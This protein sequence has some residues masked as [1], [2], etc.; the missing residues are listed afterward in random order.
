MNK[1]IE[2]LWYK[3]TRWLCLL[4]L[5]FPFMLLY[6]TVVSVRRYILTR[7]FQTKFSVPIIVVGNLT[8]GGVG[9]TPLVIEIARRFQEQGFRVGIVS[10]GYGATV[11]IFPCVVS[12]TSDP[13]LYGDEPVLIAKRTGCPVVISPKRV[14][15]IQ[16][17][18]ARESCDVIISDDG[19]QHYAMGRAIEIAV[20]DGVRQ[21]GNQHCLPAG[22]LREPIS[23]LSTVDF[24]IVNGSNPLSTS[25]VPR[26][27]EYPMRFEI[28]PLRM[29][30]AD[31][32]IS[33]TMNDE[34]IA[35]VAGIG[36]P[37]QFYSMLRNI[38]WQVNEYSFP[39]HHI[40]QVNDLNLS[41]KIIIMTEKDA[42]KCVRFANEH[43]FYYPIQAELTEQFW[44]Q[45]MS[46]PKFQS[47]FSNV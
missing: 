2:T 39:D 5:L 23:R 19:L 31:K 32:E 47:L 38:G 7:C 15:A 35:A 13:V 17:L 37:A 28:L 43:C 45:L 4:F 20:V 27:I 1:F 41:E 42:V 29:V 36:H 46:H 24:V 40:F 25:F 11:S 21:F 22:P 14:K 12:A 16:F 6:R 18:F 33:V 8:V 44:Q 3:K 34:P 9:K 10:R 26:T 30:K